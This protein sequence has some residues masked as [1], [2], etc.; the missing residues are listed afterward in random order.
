MTLSRPMISR[1]PQKEISFPRTA[2]KRELES[3][4]SLLLGD[5]E[6]KFKYERAVRL[7]Q[8]QSWVLAPSMDAIRCAGIIAA[9]KIAREIE[10]NEYLPVR[11]S[12][13]SNFDDLPDMTFERIIELRSKYPAYFKLYDKFVAPHGGLTALLDTPSPSSFD[14]VMEQYETKVDVVGELIEYRLR[15][16]LHGSGNANGANI[17]HA[18]FFTWWPTHHIPGK[19]GVTVPRKSVSPRTMSKAW[20]FWKDSA[21]FIYLYLKHGL[22]QPQPR[23]DV[24]EES[25][26]DAISLVARNVDNTR[27]LFGAYAYVAD[28]IK[29][30]SGEDPYIAVPKALPRI[31][32]SVSPFSHIE[33]Q[34]MAQYEDNNLDMWQ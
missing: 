19:R 30:I 29:Q 20:K 24:D 8:F 22:G 4:I 21:I 9:T 28:A 11:E 7:F 2:P 5:R 14:S 6:E 26:V 33:Q 27:R 13:L 3:A 10:I 18:I 25:F 1:L 15:Y 23:A 32:V 34:T 12:G 17:N 31:T 16:A